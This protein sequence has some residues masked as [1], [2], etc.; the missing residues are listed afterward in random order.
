MAGSRQ[1]R[2]PGPV[3][4]RRLSSESVAES[5]AQPVPVHAPQF[6]NFSA[7]RLVPP[8]RQ[9]SA[10]VVILRDPFQIFDHPP[11]IPVHGFLHFLFRHVL[12]QS[13]EC[14]VQLFAARSSDA[15][16]S[17][18]RRLMFCLI[19]LHAVL[20][21]SLSCHTLCGAKEN[22]NRTIGGGL[23]RRPIEAPPAG[24]FRRIRD[25]RHRAQSAIAPPDSRP[26]ECLWTG[27][28]AS[29]R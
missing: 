5:P 25:W 7:H 18:Q 19:G 21:T 28:Y 11:I 15:S 4:T 26:S 14:P 6:R 8:I 23:R 2:H 1:V 12:F 13:L 10:I 22:G 29:R 20:R 24:R 17:R 27:R 9:P 16:G 3:L